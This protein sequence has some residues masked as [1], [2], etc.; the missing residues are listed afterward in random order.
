M[1]HQ[2]LVCPEN[3][4]SVLHEGRKSATVQIRWK[5]SGESRL[6]PCAVLS[7]VL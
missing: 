6:K 1:M 3:L 7:V 4:A 2:L 5:S